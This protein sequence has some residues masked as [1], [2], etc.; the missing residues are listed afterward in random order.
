[1]IDTAAG[2]A[3]ATQTWQPNFH[4]LTDEIAV[5]GCFPMKSVPDLAD[6]HGVGAV[7]DLREEDCDD[8]ALL[9]AHG[10]AFLHLPTPD[11]HPSQ[12]D[13]LDIGV[14]FV[15]EQI[16]RG[17]KVLIHCQH[18]IGRSALLALCVLVDKGMAP[19]EALRLAKDKRELVSPSQRQYEGWSEWLT[20]HGHPVPSYPD[21]GCIAYRHLAQH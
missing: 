4:W 16:A 12:L 3:T 9:G 6:R 21:F 11:L 1:M 19:L 2:Q 10:I 14:Q 18:G 8:E 5:G 15:H 17:R 13:R 7:V 20:R